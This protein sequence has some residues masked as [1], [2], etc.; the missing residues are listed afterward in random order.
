MKL[1]DPSD[2]LKIGLLIGLVICA[3][4]A[5]IGVFIYNE[6]EHSKPQ[7]QKSLKHLSLSEIHISGASVK[8]D[9]ANLMT[10]SIKTYL[11]E[12]GATLASD[13]TKNNLTIVGEISS[14]GYGYSLLATVLV[15]NETPFQV[16]LKFS[17]EESGPTTTINMLAQAI[18][19][20]IHKKQLNPS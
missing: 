15:K 1:S 8:P 5:H 10:K 12:S 13:S 4:G 19:Y 9:I 17:E 20:E 6:I 3:F 18:T 16:D 7:E 11:S 2:K 14:Y